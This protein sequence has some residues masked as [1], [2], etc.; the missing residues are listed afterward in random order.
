MLGGNDG[1][2]P[3]SKM[4]TCLALDSETHLAPEHAMANLP[5]SQVVGGFHAFDAHEGPQGT[6][7]LSSIGGVSVAHLDGEYM[8]IFQEK[9]LFPDQP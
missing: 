8:S 6:P 7:S 5:L 1:H 4:T 2:N 3:F 9:C